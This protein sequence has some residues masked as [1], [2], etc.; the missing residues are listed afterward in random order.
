M[1]PSPGL[2]R[3]EFEEFLLF[4]LLSLHAAL[5][6][7]YQHPACTQP[8][9]LRQTADLGCDVGRQADALPYRPVRHLD[10]TIMHES[11]AHCCGKAVIVVDRYYRRS[12]LPSMHTLWCMYYIRC[13]TAQNDR[14][15]RAP[16]DPA[17]LFPI[18]KGNRAGAGV[19]EGIA[20][21]R[22]ARTWWP[23]TATSRKHGQRQTKSWH[24]R[25]S[26]R[27]S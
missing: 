6:R 16:E 9:R 17:D 22:A 14:R 4:A 26:A 20:G 15:P 1:P 24:W 3:G 18:R 10:D 27:R 12:C 8:A 11:G 25:A 13:R 23:C 5:D 21:S 19:A 2:D 7:F